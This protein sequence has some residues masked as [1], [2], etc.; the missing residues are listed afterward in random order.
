[1]TDEPG[2][3]ERARYLAAVRGGRLLARGLTHWQMRGAR[4]GEP[5]G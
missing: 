1:M 2:P 5:G 4:A 3:A